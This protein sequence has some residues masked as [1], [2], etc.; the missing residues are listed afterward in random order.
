M[1]D[2]VNTNV[3]D[4]KAVGD[5]TTN[6]TLAI[7]EAIAYTHNNGGGMVIVPKDHKFIV[8]YIRLLSNVT[9][10]IE[11]NAIIKATSNLNEFYNINDQRDTKINVPTWENCWYNG[12]PSMF[13]IF[14]NDE[15]NVGIT[16]EGIIDGNEQIFYGN[17]TKWHIEG[18]FYPRV[19]LVY[20]ENCKN[21]N[22]SNVLLQNSAFWTLHLVGCN[23]VF[24]RNI[25][26]NNNLR[27]TNSDGIDPDHCQNVLIENCNISAADDCIVLKT[28]EANK[29]YGDTKNIVVKN[30]KLTSTSAA[31]KIGSESVS[32]FENI[33]FENIVIDKSNR[34]I[35]I[36]LRDSGNASNIIFKNI[37]INTRR[38]SPIHWWGRAEAIAI[39]AIR[40]DK[41]TKVGN[42]KNI[43][44]EGINT[45]GEN[46]ILIYGENSN[47]QNIIFNDVYVN[48]ERHTSWPTN[49]IDL[50]PSELGNIEGYEHIIYAR[51]A[52]D[53]ELNDFNY[54]A[55]GF[56][57]DNLIDIK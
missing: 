20:L 35:S 22:I 7:N 34:G 27:M 24:I 23:G 48:L 18:S 37:K 30:C 3:L 26:I 49:D 33:M 2:I 46:G 29:R 16:G 17:V 43:K 38:F 51:N 53:V 21:V 31:I 8:G 39:T 5:G 40:R 54:N 50:R 41:N 28:T 1:G 10:V 47:I 12:K 9:L 25:T 19:P 36:Q 13:F 44:F 57:C 32:N 6:D 15:E 11:K 14:A 52:L 56:D 45:N 4:F 42:V 55:N